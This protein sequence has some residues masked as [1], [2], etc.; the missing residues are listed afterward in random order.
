M[1]M[2]KRHFIQLAETLKGLK[3]GGAN[4]YESARAKHLAEGAMQQWQTMVR[5]IAYICASNNPRFRS[6]T[7]FR[8]CGYEE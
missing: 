5:A 4:L 8:A 3:P 6:S 1:H 2:T 7:F